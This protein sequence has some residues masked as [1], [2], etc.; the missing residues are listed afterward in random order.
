MTTDSTVD[1]GGG[2]APVEDGD[3][4]SHGRADVTTGWQPAQRTRIRAF[5]AGRYVLLLAEGRVPDPGFEVS[6]H[7]SPLRIFPQQYHLVQRRRPGFFPAV[8]VP[9]RHAEVV[10]FPVEAPTV[11]VHHAGGSDPVDV[12]E[13]GEDLAGFAAVVS[14][15]A[16]GGPSAE[17]VGSSAGMSFDEAFADAVTNL[18]PFEPPFPDAMDRVVV[19]DTGALFGGIAGLHHLFVR[20]R[21]VPV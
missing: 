15:G 14:D 21:R 3:T 16:S 19:A 13:A 2:T 4:G 7:R 12:E 11:V 10:L 17:A 20:V 8:L 6:V 9:Y 18:P 5:R 1:L